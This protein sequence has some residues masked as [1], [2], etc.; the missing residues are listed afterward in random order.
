M[1][2]ALEEFGYR[3]TWW[4]YL[5]HRCEWLGDLWCKI[6]F[7]FYCPHPIIDDM[8]ARACIKAGHCGCNNQ[9]WHL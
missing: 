2:R 3:L 5:N 6:W 9:D 8:T 7:R 4:F 1:K